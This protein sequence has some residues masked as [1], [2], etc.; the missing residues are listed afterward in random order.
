MYDPTKNTLESSGTLLGESPERD[1]ILVVRY[2]C[3]ATSIE[4]VRLQLMHME[5]LKC[6]STTFSC[7]HA[8]AIVFSWITF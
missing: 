6:L 8:A 2:F 7:D 1:P 5:D 4:Y 3:L